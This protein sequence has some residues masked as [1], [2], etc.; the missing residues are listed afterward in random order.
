MTLRNH[1]GM[2]DTEI[3]DHLL[4][5]FESVDVVTAAGNSFFF[6]SPGP[7]PDHRRP[8]VTLMT[9]DD[10]DPASNLSRSG[11]FR[12]NIGVGQDIYRSLFGP[13][14]AAYVAPAGQDFTALDT[15]LPHPVYAVMW[16]VCVLNPSPAT[17]ERVKPLLAE[18]YG[19]ARRRTVGREH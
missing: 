7:A 3:T 2:T 5:V 4:Q 17:F 16:W 10:N 13:P 8:F 1:E 11:I 6:Y 14:P 12:L 15:L 18:A 19:Q 9:N